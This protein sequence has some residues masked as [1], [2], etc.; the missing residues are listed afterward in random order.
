MQRPCQPPSLAR[1]LPC[2]QVGYWFL[3]LGKTLILPQSQAGSALPSDSLGNPWGA[4][5]HLLGIHQ[6]LLSCSSQGTLLG[7]AM[8]T[9]KPLPKLLHGQLEP[10]GVRGW[11][12]QQKA[13]IVP[14]SASGASPPDLCPLPGASSSP[15]L[16]ACFPFSEKPLLQRPSKKEPFCCFPSEQREG[17]GRDCPF[18]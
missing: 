13:L 14:H 17:R 16:R 5:C 9:G 2:S 6:D 1:A 11:A 7:A 10:G 8:G 18:W 12:G 15:S 4:P 3:F